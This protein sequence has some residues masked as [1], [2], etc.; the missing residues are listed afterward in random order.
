MDI[1]MGYLHPNYAQSFA[2]FGQPLELPHC[3][4]WILKRRIPGFSYFDAMGCYPLFLCHDWKQIDHDLEL[5]KREIVALS[6]VTD[7]FGS[8]D[9][10]T[11]RQ[12]FNLVIPYKEH[13]VIECIESIDKII[14]KNHRYQS[15]KAFRK[16]TV[17]RCLEPWKSLDEWTK[18]YD[19]LISRHQLKGIHTFSKNAFSIQLKIPGII[20]FQALFQGEIVGAMI[21]F[22]LGE[23]GYAHLIALSETGYDL[24]ASYALFWQTLEYLSHKVHWISIGASAGI[25]KNS[26]G[27]GLDFFKRGWSNQTKTS[28]FCGRIFDPEKYS[29]IIATKNLPT[30]DYF[31]AYRKG[32]FR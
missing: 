26:S 25:T 29:D 17:E 24:N 20:M 5:L 32:E 16:V 10:D 9:L 11:L 28:Y 14:S 2:E 30:T 6:L 31:P 19:N 18:L 3:G 15:R 7:P 4:G 21:S 23:T 12:N 22:I 27:S 13:Y 8:Y 1:S